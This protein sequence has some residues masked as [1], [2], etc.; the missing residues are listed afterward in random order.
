MVFELTSKNAFEKVSF[1]PVR[2]AGLLVRF[3]W[4]HK[5]NEHRKIEYYLNTVISIPDLSGEKSQSQKQKLLRGLS[6]VDGEFEMTFSWSQADVV[7]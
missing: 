7:P 5:E 6:L 2:R 4:T 1:L 3:L